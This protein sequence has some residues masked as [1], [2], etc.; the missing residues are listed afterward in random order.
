MSLKTFKVL[1]FC[2]L[3]GGKALVVGG[4]W[5]WGCCVYLYTH[6][7]KH[8]CAALRQTCHTAKQ[9]F[10]KDVQWQNKH[11]VSRARRGPK[12]HLTQYPLCDNPVPACLDHTLQWPIGNSSSPHATSWTTRKDFA[13]INPI[14]VCIC[15]LWSLLW[16]WAPGSL[17]Q[18]ASAFFCVIDSPA[19]CSFPELSLA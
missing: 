1:F 13:S 12:G 9:E 16:V 3:V 8:V 19:A 14:F 17:T 18:E 15:I 6:T 4:W 2:I 7:L 10:K 5:W 11:K